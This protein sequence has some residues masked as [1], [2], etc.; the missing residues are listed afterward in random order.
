[1]DLNKIILIP[2]FTTTNSYFQRWWFTLV[3][4]L[5]V[6]VSGPLMNFNWMGVPWNYTV[7]MILD[8]LLSW[9][10]TGLWLAW[11]FGRR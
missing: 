4:G 2:A 3:V 5:V 1:M 8:S 11:F 6:T 9:G 7:H 10:I